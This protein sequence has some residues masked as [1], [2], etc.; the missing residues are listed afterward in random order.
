M[1]PNISE[2]DERLIDVSWN[3]SIDK[4][5]STNILV[6]SIKL[7]NDNK[8]IL[9]DIISKT[10]SSDVVVQSIN[11][12]NTPDDYMFNITI[13]VPNKEKLIKFINDIETLEDVTRVERLIK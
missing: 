12:V 2:L 7:N 1:C 4:K 8:N 6:H 10:S 3:D 13:L 11:T 9:I 5:Y